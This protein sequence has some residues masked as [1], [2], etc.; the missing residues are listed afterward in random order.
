[1]NILNYN[2]PIIQLTAQWQKERKYILELE[3]GRV[4]RMCGRTGTG[5]GEGARAADYGR[6]GASVAW[7]SEGIGEHE[8]A[9][10]HVD[11]LYG[12]WMKQT[13]LPESGPLPSVRAFAECFLSDTRQRFL[14]QEPHSAKS[15]T[16]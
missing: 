6:A 16:R 11:I 9:C 14:C 13:P 3:E 12:M 7:S 8:G 10:G 2:V 15:H 5:T 4:G 1:M